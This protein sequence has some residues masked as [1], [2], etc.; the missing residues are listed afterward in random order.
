VK[1]SHK[2][3]GGGASRRR[4]GTEWSRRD[5]LRRGGLWLGAAAG[6]PGFLAG[7]SS[8]GGKLNIACVGVGGRGWSDL[9]AVDGENIVAI[10]DVDEVRAGAALKRFG[11]RRFYRDFRRMLDRHAKEIDAVV[12]ATPDHTHAA[13][14]M[15]A[16]ELGKHVY[17]EKPLAHSLYEARRVTEAARAKGVRT[18]LGNQGH[19]FSSIRRFCEMIWSGVIGQVREIHAFCRHS[20]CPS[21]RVRPKETPPPP[22]TLD[23]DLWLGPAMWRP[24][25]PVYL[26]GK[27]RGWVPFGTGIVGDWVC[28]VV[29][30]VFWALDLGAPTVVRA[31]AVDY[32]DPRI[33][34]ET[35]PPGARIEYQFPAK[36]SRPAVKLTWHEGS[37][38]P[39]R[40][41]ELEPGR[42][43]PRIGAWVAGDKGTIMYGSHGAA[44]VQ[45][46][47]AKRMREYKMPPPT[48]PRSKGHH[49]EWIEACKGG[50]EAGSNFNYGGPLTEIALL[51]VL[52]M[53][54]NGQTLHWDARSLRVLN[55]PEANRWVRPPWREGWR[56]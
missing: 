13:V 48:L 49:R 12:A 38:A 55:L 54:F 22:K 33:R 16:I 41:P 29:D 24:Y 8:P 18:Q 10:C 11:R 53:R 14:V 17:C 39:P 42:E 30:P 37:A 6:A 34:A 15:A 44:G 51:G 26:P 28:H 25:H 20:Y 3:A 19:S 1:T 46:I 36:G 56:L 43:L 40:P 7:G 5:F 2:T 21:T 35:Y 32:A 50:P 4:A 45:L 27:W 23:W 31:E 9:Q 47:P 52:A